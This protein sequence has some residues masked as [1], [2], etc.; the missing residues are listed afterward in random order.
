MDIVYGVGVFNV[1]NYGKEYDLIYCCSSYVIINVIEFRYIEMIINKDI[2]YWN[3]YQQVDKVYY[4]IWF[5]FCKIFIL[6]MGNL[7]EQ[8]F[9]CVLQ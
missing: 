4:Y 2:V 7:E 3:V 1:R 9:W 5:G 6:V 8:I